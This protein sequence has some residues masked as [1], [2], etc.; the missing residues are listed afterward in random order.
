MPSE[1]HDQLLDVL[2]GFRESIPADT[3]V[4]D[5]MQQ[6]RREQR[7][8]RGILSVFG[9]VGG[10][11]G[12]FGAILL[13][14]PIAGLFENLPATGIMQAALITVAAGAFY[15]WFMNEDLSLPH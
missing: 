15:L 3:F 2:L 5:V 10:V 9:L 8:R 4:L 11:F 12:V 7:R 14:G 1:T 6:V 13:S